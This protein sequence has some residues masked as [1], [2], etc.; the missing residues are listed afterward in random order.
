MVRTILASLLLSISL[1]ASSETRLLEH[2]PLEWRPTSKLQLGTTPMIA[3]TV[4]HCELHRR[5][6]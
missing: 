3:T 1:I 5:A 2:I 4:T 6:R